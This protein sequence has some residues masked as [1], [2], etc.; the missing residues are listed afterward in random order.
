VQLRGKSGSVVGTDGRQLFLQSGFAFPWEDDLLVPRV[1]AFGSR[2]LAEAGSVSVGCTRT[3]VAVRA[4]PW[5]VWLAIDRT[6]RF[7]QVEDLIPPAR[8]NTPR[9]QLSPEDAALLLRVLPEL[10]GS[11]EEYSPITLALGQ[12]PWVF[13][14][15]AQHD[16]VQEAMLQGSTTVGPPLQVVMNRRYLRRAL[17]L[18]F[19]DVQINGDRSV[20]CRDEHRIYVWVSLAARAPGPT[21]GEATAAAEAAP[22]P[23]PERSTDPVPSHANGQDPPEG[24]DSPPPS[25]NP[26]DPIAEAEALRGLL[27]EAASRSARLVAALKQQRRQ[28]RAVQ[29][30]VAS[31]RQL[32]LDR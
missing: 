14:R 16:T 31:L 9:L 32:Q 22:H 30:A 25:S 19:L 3:H 2:E 13:A 4:G 5:T 12:P 27:Q 17:Q 1:A 29:Q 23:S 21:T 26:L 18:G 7:P 20:V 24:R 8:P 15:D 10:P 28:T 6:G 11:K